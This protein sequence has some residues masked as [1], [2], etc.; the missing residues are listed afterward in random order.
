[1]PKRRNWRNIPPRKKGNRPSVKQIPTVEYLLEQG[2][3]ADM[4]A[5]K[6]R[7]ADLLKYQ[8]E[9]YSELARQRNQIRDEISAALTQACISDFPFNKWQRAVK[10][11]YGLHPFSTVGSLT[12]IGGRF[13]TGEDVNLEVPSFPALYIA[14]DK[15]TALQ[16]TLGQ[17]KIENKPFT[18]IER[19]LT[20]PQSEVI[21]SV[22]GQ[23][24][25]VIDLRSTECL[26]GFVA[27]IK[28]FKISDALKD[29]AKNLGLDS[30]DVVTTPTLLL[31]TLLAENWRVNPS[32]FD[33]PANPQIFGHLA[34]QAGIEGI[35][36]PSKFTGKDCLAIFPHNFVAS[37][38]FV[39]L[40]DDVPHEKVPAQ[41]DSSNWRVC[42][43]SPKELID[44]EQPH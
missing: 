33:V 15:D 4:R 40:D 23:L 28:N 29:S 5:A 20:N 6:Q 11:K 19:A 14:C 30:P 13:N 8:W 21:V 32:D 41:I 18:P 17:I 10:Y 3:L 36:Y 35:L 31:D 22:S 12:F 1:M 43:L 44:R 9:Y 26:K 24:E 2:T 25:K 16:E 7:T 38:S 42:D 34:Y 27:L 39:K 37:S